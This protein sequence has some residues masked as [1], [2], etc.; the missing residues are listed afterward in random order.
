[1]KLAGGVE[2]LEKIQRVSLPDYSAD[3]EPD[4]KMAAFAAGLLRKGGG[5]RSR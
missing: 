4:R 1:M 5:S 3:K 2:I